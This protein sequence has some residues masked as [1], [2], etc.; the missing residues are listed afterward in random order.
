VLK[1]SDQDQLWAGTQIFLLRRAKPSF[2]LINFL[3]RISL[4][5]AA[6]LQQFSKIFNQCY[7]SGSGKNHSDPGIR[8]ESEEK[9]PKLIKL[10][11]F[12]TKAAQLKNIILFYQKIS[13]KLVSRHNMWDQYC[14]KPYCAAGCTGTWKTELGSMSWKPACPPPSSMSWPLSYIRRF[15][16]SD[17]MAY[18]SPT[19]GQQKPI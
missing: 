18:A 7:G 13:M 14:L 1:N 19:W 12:L 17:R 8:N 9:P 5:F 6:F 15:F 3:S 2:V 4:G 16:S 11:Q 10:W